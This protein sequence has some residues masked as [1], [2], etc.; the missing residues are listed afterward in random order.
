MIICFYYDNVEKQ[1]GFQVSVY[2]ISVVYVF[3]CDLQWLVEWLVD[4]FQV[5]VLDMGCGVGYVS[6]IV[7]GQVVEVI[8]YDLLS[9]MLEVVVV[10]VKE[11]GFSNIVIQQGYV[12]MLLFVDVS[13]DVV[14][15]CYF[16]YY[17]Y[18][19]GQVLCEV[20]CV[21]KLGGVIIVMDVMLLGYLV[22]D[23][24]LQMVE[25]LCD[26]LYVCNYFSGEWLMLV[27]EVGLVVNQLLID[28]LLLEF[29]LWVVWMCIFELLVEVIC[30]YQQSVLVEVKVYFELQEDGLFISDII[31]FEVY[32]VV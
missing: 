31:L 3:G 14:I 4:F 16:V 13:F 22:C 21:F 28:C 7:V 27:I 29:S 30:L 11:K 18:D 6:F 9:Q 2:L 23:V 1:F 10:V 17:W 5:K 25:V 19:V 15:S 12:E 8:V 32:K 20:K 24:W 26:I